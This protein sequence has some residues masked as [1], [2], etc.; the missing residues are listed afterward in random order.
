MNVKDIL[1]RKANSIISFIGPNDKVTDAV[2]FMCDSRIGSLLVQDE[3]GNPVGIITE[4]DILRAINENLANYSSLCVSDIMTT[5]LICG[6]L[7]DDVN[8]VMQIMTRNRIRHLPIVEK[9]RVVG[10]ISIGDVI[11]S[12]LEESRVENRRLHDYL[13]LSGEL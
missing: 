13:Q 12:S 5:E 11:N 8:Y 9:K 2:R 6:L 4:R 3:K 1:A 7:K 10:L